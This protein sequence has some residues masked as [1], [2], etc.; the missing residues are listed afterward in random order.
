VLV[1]ADGYA[2]AAQ[3]ASRLESGGL[4]VTLPDLPEIAHGGTTVVLDPSTS[5]I[6]LA[7]AD[8]ALAAMAAVVELLGLYPIE[9]L[10]ASVATA[11]KGA[12]RMAEVVAA[13]VLMA[14]AA[15]G[16]LT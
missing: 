4:V 2:G 3:A 12:D 15:P 7:K 9:A 13:G 10:Q 1:A 16:C 5:G 6:R 8:V 11:P 14:E